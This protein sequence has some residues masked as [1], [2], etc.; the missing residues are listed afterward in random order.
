MSLQFIQER[1]T[2]PNIG[3]YTTKL[4]N[5]INKFPEIWKE[6]RQPTLD[7]FVLQKLNDLEEQIKELKQQIKDLKH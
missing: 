4:S 6:E 2:P 3:L 7:T 5:S 1:F